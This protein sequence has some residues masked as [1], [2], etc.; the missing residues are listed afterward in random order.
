MSPQYKWITA[1]VVFALLWS[2]ASTA[3]KLALE[4]A[5]P[6]VI[7][8]IRFMTAGII[9]LFFSHVIK[10]NKLPTGK[11]WKHLLVYS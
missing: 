4:H 3:T 8:F 2:S 7:A 1:G 6:L 10:K 11:Q 9:M 5:Q